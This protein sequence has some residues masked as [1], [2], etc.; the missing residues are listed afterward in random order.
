MALNYINSIPLHY[1]LFKEIEEKIYNGKY[2]EK[3]P[4]ER[5][6]MDEYYVSRSTVRQAISQLVKA[7]VLERRRGMG[8]FVKIKPINDWLGNLR[9]T[10]ETIEM[11]GMVP[12]AKL[13][14]SRIVKLDSE[15]RRKTGLEEA[16]YFKRLRYANHLPLGIES[17]YYPVELGKKL[18]KF[19]LNKESF[20]HL[21][22]E[23]LGV[24]SFDADQSITA[25]IINPEDAQLMN[26]S[27]KLCVLHTQ[28]KIIDV[29]EQFVEY[30]DA[31]YR[32]DMYAFNINLSRGFN[33]D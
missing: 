21:M 32:S 7:G 20:Y 2:N 4:S 12:G 3:I 10:N 33:I 14:E 19:D 30:E 25:S 13:I 11:M 29:N 26:L 27:N 24:K 5:E 28:R 23:Q 6:L 8:T 9:S 1:Q 18:V 16:Y 17:H 22:E 31:I 15:L